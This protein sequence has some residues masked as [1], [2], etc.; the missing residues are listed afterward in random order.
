MKKNL[1]IVAA[2]FL[3]V[4]ALS[5]TACD[6]ISQLMD[7]GAVEKTAN[8]IKRNNQ[9]IITLGVYP[10]S[11]KS[12]D[13]SIIS[14]ETKKVNYWDCYEGSDGE[15]YVKLD[16]VENKE[17]HAM[18]TKYF[19]VEPLKWRVLTNNYNGTGKKLLFCEKLIDCCDY[20][21]DACPSERTIDWEPNPIYS[22]NYEYSRIRAFLNGVSY[23]TMEFNTESFH[24]QGKRNTEFNNGKGFFQLAFTDEEKSRIAT[25]AV[26]NSNGVPAKYKCNDTMDRIFLLS[27]KEIENTAYGFPSEDDELDYPSR[28]RE[29]TDFA[30]A[31]GV[32]TFYHL[33]TPKK[34]DDLLTNWLVGNVRIESKDSNGKDIVI[35]YRGKLSDWFLNMKAGIVPAL[36]LNNDIPDVLTSSVVTDVYYPSRNYNK[37]EKNLTKE[38]Y[39][40]KH[41]NIYLPAGYDKNDTSTKYPLLLLLHGM[42]CNENTWGLQNPGSELKTFLDEGIAAQNITKCIVVSLCGISDENW[43]PEGVGYSIDGAKVFGM[44]LR[45]SIL[46][47]LR[48]NFNILEGR[49]N[50]A[51]AGFSMGGEQTMIIGIGECLDLISYY[52]SFGACPHGDLGDLDSTKAPGTFKSEVENS[53]TDEEL[54]IKHLYIAVGENDSQFRPNC[55]T[56][57]EAMPDWDRVEQFDC[58]IVEGTA[59]DWNTWIFGLKQFIPIVFK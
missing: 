48:E 45:N 23:E 50:V 33:R 27:K 49:E 30:R 28:A 37:D 42:G 16:N 20:L 6:L 14:E 41:A 17:T 43:G 53:F 36:C 11:E 31:R 52:A 19:K 21:E 15:M 1:K 24:Y 18:E 57:M 55:E 32:S 54:T 47:Y 59:H 13:V 5:F 34:E 22:N 46:P 3:A 26:D 4:V 51:L 12:S 2:F 29:A 39:F 58:D 40:Q 56:Y 35:D 25:T 44:E 10:Q 8:E 9:E 7:K 38:D